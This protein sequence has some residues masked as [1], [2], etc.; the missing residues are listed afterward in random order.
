L[1]QVL[2]LF[3]AVVLV[4]THFA[5]PP[6]SV[7]PYAILVGLAVVLASV[8]LGLVVSAFVDDPE[9]AGNLSTLLVVP[10]SFLTGAFFDL[11]L[12]GIEYLPWAQGSYAMRQLMIYDDVGAAMGAA[13]LCLAGGVALFALGSLLYH[14]KRLRGV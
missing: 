4:G 5:G 3:A 12:P 14:Y 11:Q 9:Q 7:L 13:G 10:L 1:L 2:V 6:G 8:A